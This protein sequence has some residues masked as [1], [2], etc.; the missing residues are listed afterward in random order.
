MLSMAESICSFSGKAAITATVEKNRSGMYSKEQNN[1]R[2]EYEYNLP[3]ELSEE[4]MPVNCFCLMEHS[5]IEVVIQLICHP[6]MR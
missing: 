5:R 6:K 1:W 4:S 2:K 3:V